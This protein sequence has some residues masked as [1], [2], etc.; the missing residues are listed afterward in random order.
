MNNQDLTPHTLELIPVF[1]GEINGVPVQMVNARDLH[2]FLEVGKDFSNWIKDRIRQY[3][4]QENDD[5]IRVAKTGEGV[6]Q[7]FQPIE[8]HLTLD[9][10]KELSMVERN[11]KGKQARRYFIECE[12]RLLTG[13][14]ELFF[15]PITEPLT[16]ADFEWRYQ[17]IFEA[18][19]HLKK[20]TV[21]ETLVLSGAELL[22]GRHFE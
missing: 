4:F 22:A 15:Q 13:L 10:A 19:Q 1:M 3:G 2:E 17:R 14:F 7:G 9:T 11:E 6:N 5:Y 8:Y 21:V 18:Y 12:K 20:A 16:K